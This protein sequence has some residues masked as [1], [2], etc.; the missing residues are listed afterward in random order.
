MP[1]A[2]SISTTSRGQQQRVPPNPSTHSTYTFFADAVTASPSYEF[3]PCP[4][5]P[6]HG[7]R[8]PMV[9]TMEGAGGEQTWENGA[10]EY[11]YG[12]NYA[13]QEEQEQ[14]QEEPGAVYDRNGVLIANEPGSPDKPSSD[15]LWPAR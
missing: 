14:E 5:G 9:P 8:A 1:C 11:T 7:F 6:A 3:P 13:E 2:A 4:T 10:S 12:Y 15:I